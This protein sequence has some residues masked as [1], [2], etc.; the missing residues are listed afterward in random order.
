MLCVA[1][2]LAWAPQAQ[3]F[4]Y[5]PQVSFEIED[6]TQDDGVAACDGEADRLGGGFLSNSEFLN[7][8]YLNTL[9]VAGGSAHVYA[10]NYLDGEGEV[11]SVAQAM[12]ES[13]GTAGDYV[14]EAPGPRPVEDGT[15]RGFTAKC[16]S[17]APVVGGGVITQGGY[18]L[19]SYVSSIGPVDLRDPD[20]KPDDGWRA[21]VI[22]RQDGGA[23]TVQVTVQAICDTKDQ[24]LRYPSRTFKVRDGLLK[25]KAVACADG[26]VALG[27][28]VS[29]DTA[30]RHG[31]FVTD[32]AFTIKGTWFGQVQNSL[33]KDA[34]TRTATVTAICP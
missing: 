7:P 15:E 8:V 20:D 23:Q 9:D 12:C 19:E 34:K 13:D 16:D 5:T 28:G 27:G 30:Y 2:A 3:A 25:G 26:Q 22:N 10:D 31:V 29:T 17:G 21:E 4:R 24:K 33:T 14:I 18:S 32:T 11:D 6:G 1:A